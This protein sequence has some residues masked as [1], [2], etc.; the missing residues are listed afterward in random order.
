M[1]R[2]I[3]THK[4]KTSK[5]T[6]KGHIKETIKINIIVTVT[7]IVI[8]ETNT[9]HLRILNMG[10]NKELQANKLL[11]KTKDI[12]NLTK[13][14][15]KIFTVTPAQGQVVNKNNMESLINRTNN[16]RINKIKS[17]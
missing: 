11:L 3:N 1:F 16:N 2:E 14:P 9:R 7:I 15:L 4:I 10:R 17:K 8:A 6:V 13:K 12:K 5:E